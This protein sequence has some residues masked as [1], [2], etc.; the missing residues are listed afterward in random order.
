MD[1]ANNTLLTLF[2]SDGTFNLKIGTINSTINILY[3]NNNTNFSGQLD[4]RVWHFIAISTS[5][6]ANSLGQII[7]QNILISKI[8]TNN[9][10]D[11]SNYFTTQ[12]NYPLFTNKVFNLSYTSNSSVMANLILINSYLSIGSLKY[13]NFL[14]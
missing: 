8:Y 3:L 13:L 5:H 1:G 14:E 6:I 11:I 10:I 2:N 9:F 4:S 7:F 12:L